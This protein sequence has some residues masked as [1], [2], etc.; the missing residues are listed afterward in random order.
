MSSDSGIIISILDGTLM[1][2]TSSS[3]P[4]L[5]NWI[6]YLGFPASIASLG[7]DCLTRYTFL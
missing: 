5:Y 1:H 4:I 3:Y 2:L 7:S 6:R